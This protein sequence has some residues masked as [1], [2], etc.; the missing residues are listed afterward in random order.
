[1]E[2]SAD[3]DGQTD[4]VP[5]NYGGGCA[6]RR[7]MER[8]MET[9][10]RWAGCTQRA[11]PILSIPAI[12]AS[13]PGD[14]GQGRVRCFSTWRVPLALERF[15]NF[16]CL[17]RS[18]HKSTPSSPAVSRGYRWHMRSVP[19]RIWAMNPDLISTV[20]REMG[21]KGGK[22]GGKKGAKARMETLTPE[23]RTQIAQ[24]AA[25][26]RWAKARKKRKRTAKT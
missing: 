17:K 22:K 5:Q 11:N 1:M 26:A 6:T 7:G 8:A 3:P 21:R 9:K 14:F 25:K 18:K 2:S 15:A 23:R 20:M 12:V 16:S 24:K 19:I 4:S 13:N 10:R